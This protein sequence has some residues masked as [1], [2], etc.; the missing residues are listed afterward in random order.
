MRGQGHESGPFVSVFVVDLH[1]AVDGRGDCQILKAQGKFV[2]KCCAERRIRGKQLDLLNRPALA[3]QKLFQFRYRRA[4]CADRVDV[5]G[6]GGED[7]RLVPHGLRHPPGVV[8]ITVVDDRKTIE[9]GHD[10]N[11]TLQRDLCPIHIIAC[12]GVEYCGSIDGDGVAEEGEFPDV[13]RD[14]FKESPCGRH[15][16]NALIGRALK[17]RS[18]AGRQYFGGV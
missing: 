9:V 13:G 7:F 6:I 16:E 8:L 3:P 2:K 18:V 15:E 4:V 5:V 17:S 10:L 1:I 11:G 12:R 14:P